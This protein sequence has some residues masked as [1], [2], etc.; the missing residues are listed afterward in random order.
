MMTTTTIIKKIT[1]RMSDDIQ[2]FPDPQQREALVT[3]LLEYVVRTTSNL[4]DASQHASWRDLSHKEQMRVASS[5]LFG[6]E[7]NAF[8]VADTI[9]REKTV[10]QTVKNIRELFFLEVIQRWLSQTFE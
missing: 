5:L 8:L 3:E 2:T 6:L 9:I 4:L 1:K 7:E 10:I